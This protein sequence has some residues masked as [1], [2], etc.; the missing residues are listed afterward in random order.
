MDVNINPPAGRGETLLNRVLASP[1]GTD[2]EIAK[3]ILAHPRVDVNSRN[4]CFRGQCMQ[5]TCGDTPLHIAVRTRKVEFVKMLLNREDVDVNVRNKEHHG[6]MDSMKWTCGDTPLHVA[7]RTRNVE[8]V[9]MLLSR[10]DVDVNVRNGKDNAPIALAVGD[11]EIFG[12]LLDHKDV[13]INS[14]LARG[15]I[16]QLAVEWRMLAASPDVVR[17]LAM[18][19]R[20]DV[21]S[22]SYNHCPVLVWAG[23]SGNPQLVKLLLARDD[24]DVNATCPRGCTSLHFCLSHGQKIEDDADSREVLKLLLSQK[25]INVEVRDNEGRTPA[26]TAEKRGISKLYKQVLAATEVHRQT[27]TG[28]AANTGLSKRCVLM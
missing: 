13:N 9:K 23:G 14:P 18:H 27:T 21:H 3:V 10:E 17:K 22:P 26:S 2:G 11:K 6:S 25:D 15:M 1:L 12:L 20:L 16:L 4:E 7:I 28:S 8:F 5:S 19:E 24:T